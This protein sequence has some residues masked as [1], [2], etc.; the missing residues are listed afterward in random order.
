MSE[1]RRKRLRRLALG[2]SAVALLTVVVFQNSLF[3]GN[4]GVVDPGR[5]YRSAQPTSGLP[6]LIRGRSL[7]TVLNL[8]GGSPR[9]PWYAGEVVACHEAGVAFYDLP[10]S[11][12]SRPGRRELLRLIDLFGSCEYPLLIHCK[13]GSDRTGLASALYLMVARG[14]GP[15]EALGAFTVWYGHVPLLG[16][17]R[18]HEPFHEYAAWLSSRELAHSPRRFRDW[19]ARDYRSDDPPGET[20]DLRPGPRE[21]L[22]TRILIPESAGAGRVR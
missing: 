17:Q 1:S 20:A 16:T 6:G 22:F 3:R 8:R 21:P 19:V 4:F 2:L 18:L 9:D 14:L 11:A 15:E 7:S 13:S 10:M 5:V 12:T